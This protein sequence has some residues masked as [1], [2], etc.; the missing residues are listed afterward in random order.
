MIIHSPEI[1]GSLTLVGGAV[2]QDPVFSGSVTSVGDTGGS[3]YSGSFSGSFQGDGSSLTGV[4]ASALNIDLFTQGTIVGNDEL[5]FSDTDDSGNEKR[6][7]FQSGLDSVGVVSGSDQVLGG[8]GILSSSTEDFSTF[9]SSVATDFSNLSSNFDDLVGNPFT[10]SASDVTIV[11]NLLPNDDSI[12][13]GSP[14]QPF[15][16]LYLSSASLYIDGN[17]VLSSDSTELTLT[18]TVGQSL[19]LLETS[20]DTVQIQTENGDITLTSTGTGNLEL[21]APIQ[22]VAGNQIL[23]SDGNAIQFGE[24][25]DITGNITLSGTVDAVDIAD[26]KSSFDTLEGKTLVSGSSQVAL[27]G[28]TGDTDDVTEGSSNL[29][30]TDTRVKTKLDAETVVSGSDQVLDI[31]S[32]IN[33]FTSSVETGLTFSGANVT[34]LGNLDVQGTTTTVDSTTVQIG[35]NIIELNGAGAANGGM[36]VSD[37]TA[38]NT[39]TGSMIWDSTNDYWVAGVKGSEIKV[40][41]ADGDSVISGS[42]QVDHDS[43]TGF[44]ANE[45]ID[46]SGVSITAGDGLTGGGDIT[47]TRTLNIGAGTGVTVNADSIE[48]GQA[49]GTSDTVQFAKVG[50]GGAS[51]ATYELKV[52]GDIGATGDIV[53][54]ISSDERLKDNIQLIEDPINKLE[55]LRG[56]TWEWNDQASDAAKDSPNVGVIAQDVESVLPQL[57]HDRENGYKGVDYSKLVGL[58]I[59]AMKEQQS[60]LDEMRERLNNLEG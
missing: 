31:L 12:D 22:I 24:D 9:S 26:F 45:H 47:E 55:Q 11:K 1:S 29:Y 2:I 10:Q 42:G 36:Y 59:E 38:P 28:V 30:Y 18:T 40:L 46:H 56:V 8:T 44:V 27:S 37:P 32:S 52:T 48:I 43:T 54:Y 7:T 3:E 5:L 23:S 20:A 4:Q 25:L 13:L 57:V 16:D 41:L 39:D 19:K 15:K 33:S 49:V 51:D 21:D 60:Q 35:D 50:V 58:L 17:Q 14:S 34:V 6:G 53:A